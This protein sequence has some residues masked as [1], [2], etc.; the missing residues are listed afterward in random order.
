VTSVPETRRTIGLLIGAPTLWMAHF[1][2]T[3]LL[4]EQACVRRRG[5][6][7]LLNSA[8]IKVTTIAIT[9][10]FLVLILLLGRSGRRNRTQRPDSHVHQG[11]FV[12]AVLSMSG[13]FFG[14][15]LVA[16]VVQIVVLGS[17]C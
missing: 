15:A 16:T 17:P 12:D 5:Y 13:W 10:G 4:A 14:L 7:P 9:A 6:E 3:Y 1:W 11:Q 2:I 8:T